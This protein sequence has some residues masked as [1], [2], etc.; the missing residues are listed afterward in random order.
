MNE[1]YPI[2]SDMNDG[3]MRHLF[4]APTLGDCQSKFI[5]IKVADAKT[6]LT[7]REQQT[8]VRY[9]LKLDN[10]TEYWVVNKN[11]LYAKEVEKLIFEPRSEKVKP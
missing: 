11:E 5:V 9:L 6:K 1:F 8:L 10:E 2:H 3:W 4:D 7:S